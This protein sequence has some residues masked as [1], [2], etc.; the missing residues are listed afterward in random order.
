MP[1][2]SVTRLR[3]RALRFLPGFALHAVRTR[4]QVRAAPGFIGGAL[5]P[6]R[7]WTFWTMTAWTDEASMRAYI[8][9]GAHR[10]AMPRLV[11][12]CDEASIVHWVQDAADLP[13]WAAADARMRA[14]GRPSKVHH[15]SAR[16]A[17]MTYR[18]PRLT[19]SGPIRPAASV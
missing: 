9:A 13:S 19:R 6:D 2:I 18:E 1:F 11:H 15:P 3:I 5:L 14:E 12:W 7:S 16:H 8:L 10:R 17:A 4:N